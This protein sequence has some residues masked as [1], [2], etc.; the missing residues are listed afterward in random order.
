MKTYTIKKDKHY[1]CFGFLPALFKKRSFKSFKFDNSCEYDLK[2][3]D[4]FDNNKLFGWSQGMHHKNSC[5]FGWVWNLNKKKMEIHAYC[6]IK[7]ERVIEYLCDCDLDTWYSGQIWIENDHYYFRVLDEKKEEILGYT[8]IHAK[9]NIN[10]GYT[11]NP[12]F[13]GNQ[14]APH[15]MKI[16]LKNEN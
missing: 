13:G 9:F 16:F 5:R 10:I 6:Y 14:A 3:I 12:Y 11:L 1:S 2:N 4:Q 8:S 15:D 7:G